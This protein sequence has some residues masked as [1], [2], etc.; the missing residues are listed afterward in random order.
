MQFSEKWLREFVD[1]SIDT[2]ALSHLLTMAGLEVEELEPAA[3]VFSGVVVAEV[4]SV[5]PHPDADRL[6]IC[7]VNAGGDPLQIVCGAPN[8]TAGMK[9]PCATVGAKLPGIDIKR[10]K[11]RGVESSG[12]LCSAR[13]LGLS[14]ESAGLLALSDDAPVGAD[15]R[16]YLDLDD[17]VFVIKLTPNRAD[18]FG[19]TG[20]AREVAALTGAPLRL[21]EVRAAEVG[22]ADVLPVRIEHADLC[23]RFTG[24]VIRGVNARAATPDWMKRRLERAGMRSISILVDISNYVMLETN[25]PNHVFD[26]DRVSGGLHVRWASA[27][28]QLCLLN[29]QTI[30][31]TEDCGVIAD[32]GGV[33]SLAG[34]MG[35]ASTACTLDTANVYVEAAFWQPDAIQGRA[36]RYAF[37]SEAAHRFERGVDFADTVAGVERVS[38]LILRF[39]GGVAGP[40]DDQITTLP[41]RNPVRLRP[42]RAARVLGVAF[43]DDEIS[44]HLSRAG[45]AFTRDGADFVVQPPTWRF[46]LSIEEDLIEELARL[47]GYDN[48]PTH[49]PVGVLAMPVLPE[50]RRDTFSLRHLLADRDYQEVINFAFVEREWERDFAHNEAPVVL[51][52][53]IASQMSVMRSTLIG[54]LVD[55]VATNRRRQVDRVRVFEIGRCFAHDPAAVP[56]AGFAQTLRI[57]ALAWGGV[58]PEQWGAAARVADFFDVKADVDALLWP[59]VARYDVARHP[60]MHPGRTAS[61]SVG[62]EAIGFI[63]ELHPELVQRYDL[64]TAP[65]LFEVDLDPLLDVGM[66]SH[67]TLSR[68]P[69]VRRDIALLLPRAT[70]AATVLEGLRGVAP[71]L[72]QEIELFDLYQG[73]GVADT[74]KSFA[75]RI[76]MQDT[77]RTLADVDVD[78]TVHE[79]VTYAQREFGAKLRA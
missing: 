44:G 67:R 69:A 31:L 75:F 20:I 49:P 2:R 65:V 63:G 12:M 40:V 19:M 43:S 45:F 15:I 21:P 64:G 76:V 48:I 57:G 51:A 66:P 39:C 53:P 6:R 32:D 22:I 27:G 7:Q 34:I 55:N 41:A 37:S 79:L 16:S 71:A 17:N 78:A 28:E 70:A 10:A 62:G 59:R 9:V 35:G 52:N 13:E 18:C 30:T 54:G 25:R 8:V 29:D 3:A 68:L 61:I 24:R 5:V 50:A 60:A 23:G 56:V 42:A 4:L 33:E 77:Q 74:E 26:L 38:E 36:R 72:V 58:L 11:L 46:D 1:P 14:D 47:H 73:A